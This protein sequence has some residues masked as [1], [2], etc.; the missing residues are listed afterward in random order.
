MSYLRQFTIPIQGLKIGIHEYEFLI[1]DKFF[2]HFED[3]PIEEG[4]FKVKFLIDIRE[5]ML[6]LTFDLDGSIKTDCDRCLASINLPIESRE[7]LIIKYAKEADDEVDIVYIERGAAELNVA[8]YLYEYI[9]LAMP[10][11]NIYDCEDE[12][13]NVCDLKMLDYLDNKEAESIEEKK[14]DNSSSSPWGELDNFNKD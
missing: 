5:D 13:E 10:V 11:A 6:V 4:T 7:D 8:T 2:T 12:E 14:E 1:N 3:S 9:C